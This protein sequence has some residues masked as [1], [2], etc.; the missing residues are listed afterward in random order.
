MDLILD[1]NEQEVLISVLTVAISDLTDEIAHTDRYQ[2]RQELKDQKRVL[3]EIL[4][5]LNG[6]G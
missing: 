5:R 1:A 2:L 6:E 3:R 4:V